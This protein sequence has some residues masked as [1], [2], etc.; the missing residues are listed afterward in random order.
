M[1]AS[2]PGTTREISAVLTLPEQRENLNRVM[3]FHSLPC[4]MQAPVGHPDHTVSQLYRYS[5]VV[6]FRPEFVGNSH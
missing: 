1:V 5:I 3:K 4:Q 2:S 6:F